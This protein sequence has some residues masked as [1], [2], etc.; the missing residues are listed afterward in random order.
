MSV[1]AGPDTAPPR[2]CP[3]GHAR[4]GG[5]AVDLAAAAE[6]VAQFT[7]ET[8][9]AQTAPGRMEEIRRE[10]DATGTYTHTPAE[11]AFGARVAWRSCSCASPTPG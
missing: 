11:L 8:S 9:P 5:A 2:T 6:F 7:V 3:V 4:A 10:L 1:V